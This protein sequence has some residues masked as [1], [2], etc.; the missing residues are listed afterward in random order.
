VYSKYLLATDVPLVAALLIAFAL[1]VVGLEAVPNGLFTD[2]AARGY[3]AFSISLTGADMFGNFLPLFARGFDDYTPALYTYLTVPFVMLLDLSPFSTRLP[4]AIIGVLT[5]AVSYQAIRRP[6]GSLAGLAGA[7]LIAVS[8][9]YVLL[10]RIGTEWNLLALGPTLTV[11]LAYRG[12]RRPGWLIAAGVA[13]GV[14]LYG[15]APVK[16]FLP[17]LMVGFV[18]FYWRELLNQ[19]KAAIAAAVIFALLAVPVYAF[20]FTPSGLIRFREVAYF[21]ELSAWEATIYF[22]RNYLAYF[23]PSFLFL[24]DASQPNVFFI[25]RLKHVG[26]LYW[27]ELPLI[28]LGLF[29]V[30]RLGRRKHYFWLFWLLI[31]PLGINL[32]VHSPKPALWLTATPTL[33]GLA[34]AGLAYLIYLGRHSLRPNRSSRAYLQRG[35]VAVIFLVLV[36]TASV[37]IGVMIDDLFTEFPVYAANTVDWGYAMDQGIDE[38]IRLQSAFDQTNLDTFGPISGIYL[39]FYGQFP[40]RERQAEVAKYQ[41]NAWQRIGA[42]TVGQVETHTLQP[43]CHLTLTRSD[44]RRKILRPNVLLT[45]YSLPDG[46]PG[47]LLLSAVASPQLASSPVEA[48]FGEKILLD[49]FDFVSRRSGQTRQIEPGQAICVVLTWQ[50]AGNLSADYT[51]F[52]HLVGPDN[53]V[54]HSPLWAQHDGTPVEALRPTSTWQPG[55]LIQDMHVIFVPAEVP[56]GSYRLE[57]GL[58]DSVTG[59]RLPARQADG[60]A[61]ERVSLIEL[62]VR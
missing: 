19:K 40:P 24:T 61:T 30:F 37:S 16:A 12:L 23:S 1:R 15:Y 31:A 51:V 5:V 43:G 58:Y 55:E 28:I 56:S 57:V 7:A 48:V 8:P 44:K 38:L 22:A 41:E 3:D 53:P 36:I 10:S 47:S 26:L 62:E 27:F 4:S 34:G 18:L 2:E 49:S 32:H 9:W 39:A 52:V 59:A 33:Q 14:S 60:A 6:F 54:T 25:Q 35:L 29:Y 50:S 42:V 20:S 11:V 45:S 46:Q 21:N 17:L 13:G